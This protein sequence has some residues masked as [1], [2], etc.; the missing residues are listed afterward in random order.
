[1][2]RGCASF[3]NTSV[4]LK[5]TIG[6]FRAKKKERKKEKKV[7][8]KYHLR[9]IKTH[10]SLRPSSSFTL[11]S[12]FVISRLLSR[13]RSYLSRRSVSFQTMRRR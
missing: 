2:E 12:R 4:V 8:Q 11:S 5:S 6:D 3:S 10:T 9:A 1:M 7:L 13:F